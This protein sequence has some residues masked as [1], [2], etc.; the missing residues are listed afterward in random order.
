[1]PH[2]KGGWGEINSYT[3]GAITKNEIVGGG[4][5]RNPDT[6]ALVGGV[7]IRCASC[8]IATKVGHALH[9]KKAWNH[10]IGVQQPDCGVILDSPERIEEMPIGSTRPFRTC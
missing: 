8:E 5:D 10:T 9:G 2:G 1:M 4:M 6:G 7:F 3:N